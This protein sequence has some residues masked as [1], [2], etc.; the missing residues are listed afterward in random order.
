MPNYESN[1]VLFKN[2]TAGLNTGGQK[3]NKAPYKYENGNIKNP[4]TIINA[5]DIDWNSAEVPGIEGEITSTAVLL[6]TLGVMND[7]INDIIN[8]DTPI[9]EEELRDIQQAIQELQEDVEELQ[10]G[11]GGQGGGQ[12]GGSSEI[13]TDLANRLQT[14]EQRLQNLSGL[15]TASQ[16]QALQSSVTTLSNKVNGLDNFKHS[17]IEKEDFDALTNYGM[18]MKMMKSSTES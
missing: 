1:G 16:F 5:I 2:I 9:N 13:P 18:L 7:A 15:P 3:I 11:S 14:I 10:N 17:I 8:G 12:G 6:H 4:Q